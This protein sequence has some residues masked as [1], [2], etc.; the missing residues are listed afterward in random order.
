M[1]EILEYDR[2]C[3]IP[4]KIRQ[5][6]ERELKN[7]PKAYA[8]AKQDEL[9]MTWLT[10]LPWRIELLRQ[11]R[12]GSRGN[13]TVLI[14]S[15][16]ACPEQT[17]LPNSVKKALERDPRGRF[18]QFRLQA[19][20]TPLV[21][22][23]VLPKQLSQLVEEYVEEFRPKLVSS[24]DPKTLFVNGYGRCFERVPFS[25]HIR[26]LTL[27]Y[28][29]KALAPHIFRHMYAVAW[30]REHPDDYL[31]LS[32]ILGHRSV[33]STLAIYGQGFNKSYGGR[34]TEEAPR[35][36]RIAKR[37]GRFS[38]GAAGSSPLSQRDRK[39]LR[40]YQS[41]LIE[42]KFQPASVRVQICAVRA[43]LERRH[44]LGR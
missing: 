8:L 1:K 9:L 6:A 17:S 11:L 25:L 39:L 23:G 37:T 5:H 2:L 38:Q 28:T 12:I 35:T 24:A 31:T 13:G 18:W 34:H 26:S 16:I 29:R 3:K 22:R 15:R 44:A 33:K 20:K 40:M 32:K 14:K 10:V 30:L 19:T 36:R 7:D 4:T 41:Y 27:R 21:V 43:F 42:R